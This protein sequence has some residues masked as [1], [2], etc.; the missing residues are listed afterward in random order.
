MYITESVFQ[1]SA[2]D[3]IG[4][5]GADRWKVIT[6]KEYLKSCEPFSQKATLRPRFLYNNASGKE[7]Y[8]RFALPY[9]HMIIG[10]EEELAELPRYN[11]ESMKYSSVPHPMNITQ[12]MKYGLGQ[13]LVSVRLSPFAA[14]CGAIQSG[15]W[16]DYTI[17]SQKVPLKYCKMLLHTLQDVMAKVKYGFCMAVWTDRQQSWMQLVNDEEFKGTI[18]VLDTNKSPRTGEMLNVIKIQARP[19]P[20]KLIK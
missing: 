4:L 3:T 11:K 6:P 5:Y 14:C 9:G 10:F 2:N 18:Q 12:N 17:N 8:E 19:L 1:T 13:A 15:N 20:S 7:V 16:I